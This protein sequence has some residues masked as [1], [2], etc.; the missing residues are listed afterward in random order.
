VLKAGTEW[1]PVILNKLRAANIL[2]FLYSD[3]SL[4]WDWC[5]YE[6][7][8]FDG[9]QD[10]TQLDRHLFLLHWY[11]VKPAG[12]FLGLTTIPIGDPSDPGE[13][14]LK[15]MLKTLFVDSTDPAVNDNW[16]LGGCEELVKVFREP[17]TPTAQPPR[18]Y[19]CQ[20]TFQL[21]KGQVTE[22][23][24]ASGHI[25]SDAVV[26]GSTHSFRLFGLDTD[27]ER[28]WSELEARWREKV[29]AQGEG[30]AD[31]D[32]VSLWISNAAGKMRAAIRGEY[33]DDGLPLCY[34]PFTSTEEKAL[35]RPSLAQM[36]EVRVHR[37]GQEDIEAYESPR[38]G[39]RRVRSRSLPATS[40]RDGFGCRHRVERR[41]GRFC[42]REHRL[43]FTEE[44][45]VLV[46][47]ADEHLST[48]HSKFPPGSFHD[49][50]N[51]C[52]L[53]IKVL[54]R[55]FLEGNLGVAA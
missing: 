27:V 5:L 33:F 38:R 6:T 48:V 21:A 14:K 53:Q 43:E 11:D 55:S 46:A 41:R 25:P 39:S 52:G 23:A 17:F 28:H 8:Y 7:G 4:H 29:P 44:V 32:P 1:R 42:R 51:L 24:L 3:P 16:D 50:H 10:P 36:T 12:P 54:L 40:P 20:L 2:I 47:V 34:C 13:G 15:G 45:L 22:D 26:N 35:F 31:V 9:R 37:A 19:V 30:A 49:R 18:E